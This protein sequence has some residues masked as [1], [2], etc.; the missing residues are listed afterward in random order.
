MTETD[1]PNPDSNHQGVPPV[2]VVPRSQGGQGGER[3]S[4]KAETPADPRLRLAMDVLVFQ[5]KLA[6]DALR[7]LFLSPISI[8]AALFGVLT[9]SDNPG[10]YFYDLMRWGRRSDHFIGL[11]NAGLR[12]DERDDFASVDDFVDA[13]EGVIVDEHKRGGVSAEAKAHFEK[14]LHRLEETVS[15]ERKRLG[16]RVKRTADTLRKQARKVRDQI[17][18]PGS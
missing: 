8:V 1:P 9:R 13:L 3:G 18:G 17:R 6:L 2:P 4:N 14:T 5:G 7:D 16:W 12:P 15:P 11:F 10:V